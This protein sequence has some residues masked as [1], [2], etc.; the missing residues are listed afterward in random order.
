M[1]SAG[2]DEEA[3]IEPAQPGIW[4]SE[5]ETTRS[6]GALTVTAEMM[7]NTGAAFAIDRSALR[8]TV[9]GG[10]HSVDIRGCDAG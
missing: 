6:G 10:A 4:V 5:P 9:I 7:H 3:V 2:G 8:I 1:P